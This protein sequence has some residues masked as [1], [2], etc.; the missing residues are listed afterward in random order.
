MTFGLTLK[1]ELDFVENNS[2]IFCVRERCTRTLNA[3]WA[4]QKSCLPKTILNAA[5]KMFY[6][7]EKTLTESVVE[8]LKKMEG[9]IKMFCFY[10]ISALL[11]I[12]VLPLMTLQLV[13][14]FDEA[15]TYFICWRFVWTSF[16]VL[17]WLCFFRITIC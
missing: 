16:P 6:L 2:N 12:S 13:W 5:R 11:P 17:C 7:G 14:N 4:H 8:K 15:P 1:L 3:S 10:D 9:T